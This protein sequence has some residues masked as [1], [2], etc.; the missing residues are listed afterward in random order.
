M[1]P[2]NLDLITQQGA[3]FARTFTYAKNGL[4]WP[5]GTISWSAKMRSS[6]FATAT[7]S[8][9]VA[10]VYTETVVEGVTASYYTVTISLTATQ[11]A[12]I[13]A[14]RYRWSKE[15]L[16]SSDGWVWPLFEGNFF[17]KAEANK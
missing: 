5:T 13:P 4:A 1:E 16:R 2:Y 10:A 15:A 17:I 14:G 9:T 7:V 12:A 11:T 6:D 3:T 8:F